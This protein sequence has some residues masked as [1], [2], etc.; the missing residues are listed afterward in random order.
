MWKFVRRFALYD[1][2]PTDEPEG[3]GGGGAPAPP[4]PE[5]PPEVQMI[6]RDVLP[7]EFQDFSEQELKLMLGNVTKTILSQREEIDRY[8][9][10]AAAAPPPEPEPVDTR[11]LEERILEDPESVIDQVIQ[12]RYGK[13][14][15]AVEAQIGESAF[16]VAERRIGREVFRENEDEIRKVLK[17]NNVAP[18]VETIETA[19]DIV[20]GR[21]ARAG[22]LR[23]GRQTTMEPQTLS[24]ETPP[25]PGPPELSALEDEI[26]RGIG[27]SKEKWIARK[28]S[29]GGFLEVPTG[30]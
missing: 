7:A 9:S 22:R 27:I 2:E 4:E 28:Q 26:R 17:S 3:G 15:A 24:P 1:H 6:P 8:R 19:L 11:P 25:D 5:L 21:K 14:F 23:Q 18:T 16:S 30:R 12:S 29:G 20:L 13:R 10:Q